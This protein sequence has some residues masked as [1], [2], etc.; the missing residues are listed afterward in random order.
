MC[1]PF[2]PGGLEFRILLMVVDF[3]GVGRYIS[4]PTMKLQLFRYFMMACVVAVVLCGGCRRVAK[5][6][7]SEQK[8]A[9]MIKAYAAEDSGD[10]KKALAIYRK[11][12]ATYPQFARPHLD[13]GL[14]YQERFQ[15]YISAI[16]HYQRYLEMRPHTEKKVMIKKNIKASKDAFAT[17]WLKK[18]GGGSKEDQQRVCLELRNRNRVLSN[19]L[20]RVQRELEALHKSSHGS[21]RG[22]KSGAAAHSSPVVGSK[23]EPGRFSARSVSRSHRYEHSFGPAGGASRRNPVIQ[24]YYTVK[25]TASNT[26]SDVTP[27]TYTVRRGETLSRIALRVY[28]DATLWPKIQRANRDILGSSVDVKVGQV[29][30]IP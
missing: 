5:L 6:D 19:R 14:L 22:G 12:I 18:Q 7:S 3:V 21:G 20:S 24:S 10:Y 2:R 11:T 13:A 27:R 28:G 16:Y 23:M 29:L 8:S 9:L 26:T 25:S 15:D 30:K 4:I 1:D 17:Q